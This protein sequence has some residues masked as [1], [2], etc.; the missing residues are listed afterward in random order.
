MQKDQ[1]FKLVI[2][3]DIFSYDF[4]I[5]WLIN[6]VAM[7]VLIQLVY[8]PR[9]KKREFNFT[10]FL[11]NFVVFLLSFIMVNTLVFTSISGAFGIAAAFTL[12]RFRT[13]QISIKDMTYLFIIL[14]IGIINAIMRGRYVDLLA[15]N[16]VI[17]GFA[18]VAD[19]NWFL[20]TQYV[21]IIEYD[22]LDNIQPARQPILIDDLRMKTGLDIKRIDIN[23]VDFVRKRVEVKIYYYE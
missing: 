21:K 10:F 7:I 18:Y 1:V 8:Y 16:V 6:T 5:Q 13:E 12:L 3:N 15:L 20:R 2:G 9:H 17:I 22:N 19:S 11:L 23:N 4:L 14:A